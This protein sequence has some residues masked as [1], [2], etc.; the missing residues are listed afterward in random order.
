MSVVLVLC[1]WRGVLSSLAEL[2]W[3]GKLVA[4]RNCAPDN[5]DKRGEVSKKDVLERVHVKAY[6]T[7]LL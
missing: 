3:H 7:H 2:D 6:G 5:S 4:V 1:L